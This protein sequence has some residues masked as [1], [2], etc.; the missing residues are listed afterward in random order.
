LKNFDLATISGRVVDIFYYNFT[1]IDREGFQGYI[2]NRKSGPQAPE[3]SEVPVIPMQWGGAGARFK[4]SYWGPQCLME[5][6]A[7][8]CSLPLLVVLAVSLNLAG[9]AT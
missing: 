1:R 5:P 9:A 7:P 4:L 6:P 2:E 8:I 3:Q